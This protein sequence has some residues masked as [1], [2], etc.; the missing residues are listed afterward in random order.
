MAAPRIY[1]AMAADGVFFASVARLDPKTRTPVVGIWVQA[2]WAVLLALSGS[3][4]QLLDWVVFG[5]WIFFGL[6][7]ATLFVYRVRDRKAEPP[8][9]GPRGF[10]VP[11]HPVIP[12]MFVGAAV[13][14]VISSVVSNPRNAV[15]GTLLI[16]AGLPAFGA[17]QRRT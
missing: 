12:V 2:V 5:D 6:I 9:G 13:F 15:Y 4:A 8:H 11:W 10:R 17:W 14:V 3:Y 1:Q 16:G 7:V